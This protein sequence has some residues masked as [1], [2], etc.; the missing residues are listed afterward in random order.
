VLAQTGVR[1]FVGAGPLT[2]LRWLFQASPDRLVHWL[3]WRTCRVL[4]ADIG[5][6]QQFWTNLL[7]SILYTEPTKPDLVAMMAAISDFTAHHRPKPGDLTGWSRPV[8]VLQS[9]RDRAFAAQADEIRAAYPSAVFHIIAGAGHGALFSHTDRYLTEPPQT[10]H[11]TCRCG[12]PFRFLDPWRCATTT[13]C[14]CPGK[15]AVWFE[16][17][18]SAFT[19]HSICSTSQDGRS[20]NTTTISASWS[21]PPGQHFDMTAA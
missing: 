21:P 7:R 3:V 4:L 5:P 14:R 16:C 18:L 15:P 6:D 13:S 20:A 17:I 11:E 12:L 2:A 1:H 8:L 10:F 19:R 9:E